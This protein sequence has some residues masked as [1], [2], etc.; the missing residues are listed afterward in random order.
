MDNFW[1]IERRALDELG[2]LH[3]LVFDFS[4]L[5]FKKPTTLAELQDTLYVGDIDWAVFQAKYEEVKQKDILAQIRAKRS[6]LLAA[7]D[8]IFLAD[9]SEKVAN[10]QEWKTY[11]QALRDM[12]AQQ[13]VVQTDDLTNSILNWNDILPAKP[14]VV[15]M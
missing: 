2:I 9:T 7:S 6:E 15:Y 5:P 12:P 10:L 11:R 13:V 1:K 14:S 3:R 4:K 8:W